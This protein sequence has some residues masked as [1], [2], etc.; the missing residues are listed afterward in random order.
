MFDRHIGQ[1]KRRELHLDCLEVSLTR[2]C[3]GKHYSGP[4][5]IS[6]K[7]TEGFEI[8]IYSNERTS[9]REV[10]AESLAHRAGVVIDHAEMFTLAAHLPSGES[11]IAKDV[12]PPSQDL[13]R[14]GAGAVVSA[15]CHEIVFEESIDGEF[16]GGSLHLRTFEKFNFPWMADSMTE[17][18]VARRFRAPEFE[19]SDLHCRFLNRE[20]DE[21]ILV[22]VRREKGT[23]HS[24]LTWRITE[25]ISFALGVEPK[26]SV[27]SRV[28]GNQT[29]TCLRSHRLDS[30]LHFQPPPLWFAGLDQFD[31]IWRMFKLYLS[32]VLRGMDEHAHP[33]SRILLGVLHA[34]GSSPQGYALAAVVAVESILKDFF[35]E[36]G[37]PEPSLIARVE[38]LEEYIAAW[39]GDPAVIRRAR[40]SVAQLKRARPDDKL[41][42]L[43]AMGAI[44]EADREAWKILRNTATHGDWS[45]YDGNLQRLLD[46]AD[47]VR[48]L[49]YQLVFHLIGYQGK[50]T[51]Y[52][53]HGWPTIAYPSA[54]SA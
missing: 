32:Y 36:V 35:E 6:Q 22:D 5:R 54:R 21:G 24:E 11:I 52:G 17:A 1:L 46:L 38:S 12:A 25:A 39:E 26:W 2:D 16:I 18:G 9:Q 28:A 40:G 7:P 34:R 47:R 8:T 19:T 15:D 45:R 14:D 31:C 51:E 29:L 33:L 27:I 23:L 48:G 4:G 43:V 30:K 42:Q 37:G 44:D 41:S 53:T 50:R 49:I 3:D 10:V 20:S 13:A